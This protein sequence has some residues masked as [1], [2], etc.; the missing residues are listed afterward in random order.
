MVPFKSDLDIVIHRRRRRRRRRSL[1]VSL[2]VVCLVPRSSR[3]FCSMRVLGGTRFLSSLLLACLLASLFSVFISR[4]RVN[5]A[6]WP[7]LAGI[8]YR[9][10]ARSTTGELRVNHSLCARDCSSEL[11]S[12]GFAFS[13]S[14]LSFWDLFVCWRRLLV[15]V[16]GSEW[17]RV[18]LVKFGSGFGYRM[19]VSGTLFAFLTRGR[20]I[21]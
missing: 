19:C 15:C 11:C 10:T 14:D 12:S 5:A 3:W 8:R 2:A 17:C 9:F 20:A 7:L 18:K 6:P 1:V 13:D 21:I 16:R 4:Y